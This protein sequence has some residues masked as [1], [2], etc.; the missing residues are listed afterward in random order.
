MLKNAPDLLKLSTRT[1]N[2]DWLSPA[3]MPVTQ[4][5]EIVALQTGRMPVS[6]D[7]THIATAE[8]QAIKIYSVK[9]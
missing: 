2:T 9:P 1:A 4:L 3:A 7:S 8:L 5:I 6:P